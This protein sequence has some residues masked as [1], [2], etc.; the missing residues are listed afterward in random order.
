MPI[1]P[2][3]REL[4]ARERRSDGP[5]VRELGVQRARQALAKQLEGLERR[6][7]PA[8][9]VDVVDTTIASEAWPLPVRVFTPSASTPRP[10]IVYMHG[11]GWA[12]GSI[13][14]HH[15]IVA[16]LAAAAGATVV[17]VGY[18]L[19]PETPFPG[20]LDDALSAV[21]WAVRHAE[22][23]G[24]DAARI[25][26][27]G[28]S[29]GASLAAVCAQRAREADGPP[30]KA[31]LLFYPNT[32]ATLSQPSTF[33]LADGYMLDRDTIEWGIEQ[34]VPDPDQRSSPLVSPLL[35]DDVSGVAE[36][37]VATA[38]FDLLRDDGDRY[39]DR[40]REAGVGVRHLH[41]PGLLHGFLG[42][43]GISAACKRAERRAFEA[44]RELLEA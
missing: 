10:A 23:L 2:D 16:R 6:A 17:S 26:V 33:D 3:L 14:T 38:E 29:A 13:S 11:G 44:A 4:V 9:D 42:F 19:A 35:A 37:V 25:A 1:D 18:R 27:A 32:D 34:Y 12:Y 43:T 20:A 7:E 15:G 40:L 28:D 21:D 22:P 36:A 31:Q 24:V 30:L 41:E 8:G 39:A 5:S